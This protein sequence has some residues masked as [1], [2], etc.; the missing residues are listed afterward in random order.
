ML[1]QSK[2]CKGHAKTQNYCTLS[3]L[4]ATTSVTSRLEQPV[5]VYI[6]IMAS[7]HFH[8]IFECRV[9]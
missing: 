9:T 1:L 3:A 7:V 5:L 2:K 6:T 8:N 4:T